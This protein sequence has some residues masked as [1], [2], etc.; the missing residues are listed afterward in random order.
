MKTHHEI[1]VDAAPET[2]WEALVT[3]EDRHRW[4]SGVAS[5]EVVAGRPGETGFS[6]RRSG[7]GGEHMGI[8]SVTE[9]RRPDFLAV[10]VESD[11]ASSLTVHRL[12]SLEGERTRWSAWDN[13]RFRGLARMTSLWSA[14]DHR[15]RL[16]NDMQRLKLLVE[17]RRAEDAG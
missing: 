6:A 7:S 16:E 4:Q 2:L 9:A 8:E 14:D 3:V 15:R 5:L 1:A 11:S 17:T 12:T 13:T 10:L